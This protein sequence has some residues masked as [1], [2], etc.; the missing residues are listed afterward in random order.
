MVVVV[1][2]VGAAVGGMQTLA[3]ESKLSAHLVISI[4]STIAIIISAR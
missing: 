1:V 4:K 3:T 2:M